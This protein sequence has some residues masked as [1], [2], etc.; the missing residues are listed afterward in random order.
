MPP[1]FRKSASSVPGAG[2]HGVSINWAWRTSFCSAS[3]T[4]V[5]SQSLGTEYVIGFTGAATSALAEPFITPAAKSA[6]TKAPR[7]IR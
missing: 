6:I 3:K 1:L 2:S 4:L 7:A 5:D